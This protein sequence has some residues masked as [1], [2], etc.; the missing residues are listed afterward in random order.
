LKNFEATLKEFFP[1]GT[2]KSKDLTRIV[3]ARHFHRIKKLLDNTKGEIMIGGTTDE[4]DLFIDITIV[5]I[6]SENDALLS[7]EIFGPIFPYMV[8][9]DVNEAIRFANRVSGTPLALYAFTNKKKEQQQ[10][11]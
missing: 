6:D 7:E 9:D 5:K 4:S 1:E 11:T 10:S 2:Q 8:V 3:N